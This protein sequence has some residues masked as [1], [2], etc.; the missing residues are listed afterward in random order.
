[1]ATLRPSW[2]KQY[3]I[4]LV[5]TI[6]LQKRSAIGYPEGKSRHVWPISQCAGRLKLG[7][8][9]DHEHGVVTSVGETSAFDWVSKLVPASAPDSDWNRWP[10]RQLAFSK[11]QCR[12]EILLPLLVSQ[13]CQESKTRGRSFS[14]REQLYFDAVRLI[15]TVVGQVWV[16]CRKRRLFLWRHCFFDTVP[17]KW[18]P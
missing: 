1:M 14:Q 13:L 5:S 18:E 16:G 3:L 2:R 6:A 15:A 8:L 11:E 12:Q 10:S 9:H 4:D 17:I 7:Q